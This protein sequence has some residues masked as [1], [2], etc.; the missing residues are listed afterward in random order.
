[1]NTP[2]RS[3]AGRPRSSSRFT[4]DATPSTFAGTDSGG[5]PCGQLPR[6]QP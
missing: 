6:P 2:G 5:W 1:M 3:S 4:F